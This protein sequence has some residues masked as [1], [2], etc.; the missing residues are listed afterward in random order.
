MTSKALSG[1][2]TDHTFYPRLIL[3]ISLAISVIFAIICWVV[4]DVMHPIYTAL[5]RS[6]LS[7]NNAQLDLSSLL[8]LS[9]SIT[10]IDSPSLQEPMS[11]S[12]AGVWGLEIVADTN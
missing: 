5:L 3:S 12:S 10:L 6:N 9:D 4:L 2:I 1:G 8:Q 11:S 7:H